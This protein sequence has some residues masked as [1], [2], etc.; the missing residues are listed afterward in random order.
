[1]LTVILTGGQSRRMGRDKALLELEGEA[2]SLRLAERFS[3]LG[4]VAFAVDRAG[5]F[6]TGEYRE[7]PDRYPAQ[8]PLNGLV[9]AFSES[10][11]EL[12]LLLATDMPAADPS[13]VAPLLAAL[14]D[15][16]A[17]I[18]DGEPLFGLYTRCCLAPTLDCLHEGRRSFGALFERIALRRLPRADEA[19]F[20]NL[21]TPDDY[22]RY[23]KK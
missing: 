1:M 8:G 17:C 3:A 23:R 22:E 13:A 9:S 5:R 11:E 10:D 7:L 15:Y 19:L 12:V 18:Y 4:P 14:G 2:M 21:N 16:D 20:Q 6:P